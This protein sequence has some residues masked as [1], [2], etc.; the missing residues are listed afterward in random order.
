MTYLKKIA[1]RATATPQSEPLLGTTQMPNSAGGYTWAVDDWMR[2]DRFLILGS[3]GGSYYAT[4]RAL[5][6]ENASAVLRCI[7]ADGERVVRRIVDIS[8]AGRAPKNDPAIFALALVA[9][10]GDL[11]ARRAAMAA[12][13]HV[14]RIGT[15]LFHFAQYVEQFRGWGRSLRGAMAA[16][17]TAMPAR[18]L[19]YQAIKYRQRDGWSHRDLLRLAHPKPEDDQQAAL[20]HWMTQGWPGV[21]DDSHPDDVLRLIWAFERAQRATGAA[22]IVRLIRDERLPREAVPT[23][24]LTDATVWD[25]LL[26][27]MPMTAMI[28]NL[29]TMTR[30]GLLDATSAATAKIVAALGDA[31]RLRAARV[32]PI[33]V[34]AALMTYQSG[35]G[36]RGNTTWTSVTRI[37]D[38]LDGAFY[39]AFDAVEPTGK[40]WLL[41]LDV[42]GSMGGGVVAG[43]PGLTP[44]VASAAMAL[45]TA[46]TEPNYQTLAFTSVRYDGTNLRDWRARSAVTPLTISPRQRLDDVVKSVSN[47]PFGGTDCALP[48]LW[49]LENKAAVDVFI[50][51]TDN[52]TWAGAMHPTEALRRYREETGIPAT[53]IVVGMVS[54]GFSIADPDD[55]GMLDVVGFD[56]AAPQLIADFAAGR[57]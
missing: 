22:E 52:E 53:L 29:A 56:T 2:L 12:V 50:I 10:Q 27:D 34:L 55:A 51:Y 4:E 28:R 20:F 25:A 13:P 44:R 31:T 21:G 3:E 30:V 19:A 8:E 15:H 17:Y 48:M 14:C 7:A 38:A 45:V 1:T 16:W 24:W 54:N 35:R 9:S 42:S 47:L 6:A 46:A 49:A 11:A 37:V 40:R 57:A 36:M 32:H 5:T 23:E 18:D 33:A 39:A 41:A 26:D 43:V